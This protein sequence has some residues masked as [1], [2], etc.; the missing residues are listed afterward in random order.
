ME[1]YDLLQQIESTKCIVAGATGL[2]MG[3][4]EGLTNSIT[5]RRNEI[6]E[7]IPFKTIVAGGSAGLLTDWAN[8]ISPFSDISQILTYGASGVIG[9]EIGNQLTRGIVNNL[10]DNFF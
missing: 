8:A 4:V 5:E 2:I 6:P 1:I 9:Y 10:Y 3:G 7:K